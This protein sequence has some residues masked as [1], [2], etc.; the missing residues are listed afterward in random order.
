MK[1]RRTLI[2]Y[3]A[4]LLLTLGLTGCGESAEKA[5]AT[6]TPTKSV[7]PTNTPTPTPTKSVTPTN[8]P[9]PTVTPA[10]LQTI[11]FDYTDS[12]GYTFGIEVKISPW[13]LYS[14][15]KSLIESTWKSVGSNK[16]ESTL[17]DPE[18]LSY[19]YTK[20][21]NNDFY[22]VSYYGNSV[23]AFPRDGNRDYYYAV[24]E[25]SIRNKTKGNQFSFTKD[26]P[27]NGFSDVISIHY[28]EAIYSDDWGRRNHVPEYPLAGCVYYGHNGDKKQRQV[29]DCDIIPLMESDNWGPCKFVLVFNE[30]HTPNA[31]DGVYADI[32]KDLTWQVRKYGNSDPEP[33]SMDVIR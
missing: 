16:D 6:P 33:F 11:T 7:T 31:P 13:M 2:I 22:Q 24:G 25:V 3:L 28:R 12:V 30:M 27:Y 9:T 5:F 26:N 10:Q 21:S 15:Q 1:M 20:Y 18:E 23:R 8:T 19:T 4:A 29:V 17:F 32:I 14:T